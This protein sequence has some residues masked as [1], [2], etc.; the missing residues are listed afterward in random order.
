MKNV[1]EK[2][3][4]APSGFPWLTAERPGCSGRPTGPPRPAGLGHRQEAETAPAN[5]SRKECRAGDPALT[6]SLGGSDKQAAPAEMTP[7]E[8]GGPPRSRS[9]G[10]CQEE[11]RSLPGSV[12]FKSHHLTRGSESH[13]SNNCSTPARLHAGCCK[14]AAPKS[15]RL[16]HRADQHQQATSPAH[17]LDRTCDAARILEAMECE[18][19]VFRKAYQG[20]AGG[21]E[22]IHWPFFQILLPAPV[23]H[24]P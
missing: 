23:P 16:R 1:F 12:A 3:F 17:S 22:A 7:R 9:L 10:H 18:N 4:K 15:Q 11:I 2:T 24:L 6:E 14:A 21:G 5:L 13:F 8:T 19:T 20:E